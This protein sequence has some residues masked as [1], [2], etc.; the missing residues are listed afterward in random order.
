MGLALSGWETFGLSILESMASGNAQIGASTGAAFE[1]VTESGAGK[2]LQER[3]PHA[4]AETIVELY[5][6][7]M[8]AMKQKARAYAEKFSWND[9]FG[10]QLDLYRKLYQEKRN[11]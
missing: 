8:Q 4:L 1:H 10:R 11:S 6:S 3:T 2:I 7:D 9:C 5:R